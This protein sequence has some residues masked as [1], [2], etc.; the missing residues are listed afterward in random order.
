MRAGLQSAPA[1]RIVLG[2]WAA[3]DL[4]QGVFVTGAALPLLPELSRE[5]EADMAVEERHV[6]A[7]AVSLLSGRAGE[8]AEAVR[9]LQAVRVRVAGSLD[10]AQDPAR[11]AALMGGGVRH[12]DGVRGQRHGCL[13][14]LLDPV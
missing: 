4:H 10:A 12:Q 2:P 9:R 3:A 6:A 8:R 13:L 14:R 1:E 7:A 11:L 5:D